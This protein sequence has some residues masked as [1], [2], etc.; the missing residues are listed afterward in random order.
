M[1][2]TDALKKYFAEYNIVRMK[3]DIIHEEHCG[4]FLREAAHELTFYL[5][6]DM[7]HPQYMLDR[8]VKTFGPFLRENNCKRI[9]FEFSFAQGYDLVE[10]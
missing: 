5:R 7:S 3:W 8:F 2:Y 6:D 10:R 4:D 1:Y 9:N